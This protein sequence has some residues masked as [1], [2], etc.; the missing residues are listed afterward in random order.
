MKMTQMESFFQKSGAALLGGGVIHP[1][2]VE[3]MKKYSMSLYCA[4]AGYFHAK[5]HGL[6]VSG[7]VGDLDSVGQLNAPDFPVIQ[8]DDQDTTDLEKSLELITAPHILCYGFLGGRLDHSM[9]AFN[10]I[11]KSDRVAF[12]VDAQDV[13]AICPPHL[14]LSLPVGTR[15]SIF[16]LTDVAAR[17]VGLKWNV[18]G[19]SLSPV[20]IVSTSNETTGDRVQCWIDQGVAVV[21]FPREYIHDVLAQWPNTL[22]D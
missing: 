14:Y 16:P 21:I 2:D 7:L 18:D 20:G 5:K 17:S 13:C 12:L 15:F 6:K 11:A 9:A 1:K 4:D 3:E 10:A 8:S 19:L 22:A